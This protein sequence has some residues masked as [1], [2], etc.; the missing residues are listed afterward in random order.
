MFFLYVCAAIVIELRRATSV[1][2]INRTPFHVGQANTVK[3]LLTL[4]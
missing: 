4:F 1:F 2:H 3:T